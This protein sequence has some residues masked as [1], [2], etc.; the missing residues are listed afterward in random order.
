MTAAPVPG[1]AR[2]M[3]VVGLLILVCGGCVSADAEPQTARRPP[4]PPT[5][6]V[7]LTTGLI[8]LPPGDPYLT[9]QLWRDATDPLPHK[10]SGLLLRNGVRVGVLGGLK[11]ARF[12][13][14]LASEATFRHGTHR[15]LPAGV[16]KVI[17][18]NGPIDRCD[19]THFADLTGPG[20]PLAMT[21][22]E[23]GLSVTG[24]PADGGVR[25]RLEPVAQYGDKEL[26]VR[27]TDAGLTRDDH[28]PRE[29]FPAL[30]VEVTLSAGEYL[31]VGTTADPGDT[32]GRAL[33]LDATES[34]V[35]QRVLVV[36]ADAPQQ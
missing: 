11:P 32:L 16:A 17:P 29:V 28:R 25:L 19:L 5:T 18:M 26:G 4:V 13:A 14:L 24:G 6:G 1:I 30:A 7:I 8:E 15:T 20:R 12:D 36:R 31:V 22:A 21:A 27:L 34:R 23:C 9:D 33:F 2:R 3:R 35:R 10:L